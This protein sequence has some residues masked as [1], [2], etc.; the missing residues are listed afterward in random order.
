MYVYVHVCT[1][2]LNVQNMYTYYRLHVLD[3]II[4]VINVIITVIHVYIVH[5]LAEL[6]N[7]NVT[8]VQPETF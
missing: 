1:T 4:V 3:L 7:Y 5:S 2:K 6:M 8:G